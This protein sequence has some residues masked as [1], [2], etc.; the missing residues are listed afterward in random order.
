MTV[1][2]MGR[3]SQVGI[4]TL[5]PEQAGILIRMRPQMIRI[6]L[7]QGRFDFG[8]AV[9]KENGRWTYNIIAEKVYRYAE[10]T[11]EKAQKILQERQKQKG[12]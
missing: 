11:R 10:I 5:S 12:K 4:E 2:N 6:G 1:K 9:Q 7:Q 3:K 8:T